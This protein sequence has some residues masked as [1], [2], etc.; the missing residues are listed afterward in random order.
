MIE[1]ENQRSWEIS[2]LSLKVKQS[3]SRVWV[4]SV[5]LREIAEIMTELIDRTMKA[6]LWFWRFRSLD[7]HEGFSGIFFHNLKDDFWKSYEF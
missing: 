7:T 1:T 4:V 5:E 3:T 2:Y 6:K